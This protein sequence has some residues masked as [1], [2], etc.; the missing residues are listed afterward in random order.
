MSRRQQRIRSKSLPIYLFVGTLFLVT[1]PHAAQSWKD[2]LRRAEGLVQERFDLLQSTLRGH[3]RTGRSFE[4]AAPVRIQYTAEYLPL[5]GDEPPGAGRTHRRGF[6]RMQS[7]EDVK[8]SLETIRHSVEPWFDWQTIEDIVRSGLNTGPRYGPI[9]DLDVRDYMLTRSTDL[10]ELVLTFYSGREEV[11]VSRSRRH[12]NG[13]VTVN[14]KLRRGEHIVAPI[15]IRFRPVGSDLR[16]IDLA[17]GPK[18][19]LKDAREWY[20]DRW[21]SSDGTSRPPE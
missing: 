15:S 18:S 1:G 20:F 17:V 14:A 3:F 6:V 11:R 2:D 16:M 9:D 4:H 21:E 5:P 7:P 10:L 12:W 19:A 13:D 8:A